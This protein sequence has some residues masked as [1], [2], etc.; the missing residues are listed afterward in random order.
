MMLVGRDAE[1]LE[2]PD[3]SEIADDVVSQIED[4]F[5]DIEDRLYE[6]PSDTLD[7]LL[8]AA[9]EHRGGHYELP[10]GDVYEEEAN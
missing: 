3:A 2:P 10:A 1:S 5:G 8:E 7:A 6:L 9:A 4:R